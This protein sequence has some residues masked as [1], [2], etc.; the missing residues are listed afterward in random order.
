MTEQF[1]REHVNDIQAFHPP[2][3]YA[4]NNV[5]LTQLHETFPCRSAVMINVQTL[6]LRIKTYVIHPHAPAA[7]KTHLM[8]HRVILGSLAIHTMATPRDPTCADDTLSCSKHTAFTHRSVDIGEGRSRVVS[9]RKD[10]IT[11]ITFDPQPGGGFAQ[12]P[13]KVLTLDTHSAK[14]LG[15]NIYEVRTLVE[16]MIKGEELDDQR[17]YNLG[18]GYIM[19]LT[20]GF[21]SVMLRKTYTTPHH[22]G[23]H[24]H[25]YPVFTFK[26]KEFLNFVND[27][28]QLARIMRL[29]SLPEA[30]SSAKVCAVEDCGY[31]K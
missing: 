19:L 14:I 6:P 10:G 22:P 11:F 18:L 2:P 26:L 13:N 20:P 7:I 27:W 12:D 24:F 28:P 3:C 31:C 17:N 8:R 1:E 16:R 29:N 23:L 4:I 15:E 30:C 9:A 25:G 5:S 21:A